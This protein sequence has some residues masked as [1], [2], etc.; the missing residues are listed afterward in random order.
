MNARF[1]TQ[2]QALSEMAGASVVA[3][4]LDAWASTIGVGPR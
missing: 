1:S 2:Y 3:P 4:S